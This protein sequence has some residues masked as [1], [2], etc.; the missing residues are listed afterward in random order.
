[1][2]QV[3]ILDAE[4]LS[5]LAHATRRAVCAQRARAILTVAHETGAVVRV[6]APVLAEVCRGGSR[7][8]AVERV[9]GGRGIVVVDLTSSM[10]RRAGA[11]LAAADLDSA[12]AVDA[13][14]VA[15]ALTL[16]GGT[17]ATHDPGDIRKLASREPSIRV[18]A[19]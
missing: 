10:A 18:W 6:P 15:T 11:L 2:A 14:V 12:H 19:I 8:A 5:A 1:V 4:A 3:L 16:G 17:I 13:F 7:D 9:L